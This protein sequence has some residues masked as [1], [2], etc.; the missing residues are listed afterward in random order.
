[1][2]DTFGVELKVTHFHEKAP[3]EKA[4]L[5][6]Y[7]GIGISVRPNPRTQA[8]SCHDGFIK[9]D[10]NFRPQNQQMRLTSKRESTRASNRRI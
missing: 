5:R 4:R 9:T 10:A 7:P 6:I 8:E 2:I 3:I 1:M